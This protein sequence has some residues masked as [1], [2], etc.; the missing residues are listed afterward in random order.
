MTRTTSH[1]QILRSFK[2]FQRQS[3]VLKDL[4]NFP[5]YYFVYLYL[6]DTKAL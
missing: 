3:T 5:L 4:G 2:D 6:L 1:K